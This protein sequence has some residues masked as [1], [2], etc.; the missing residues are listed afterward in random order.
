M[1]KMYKALLAS[2]IV[3]I[4]SFN[5]SAQQYWSGNNDS[6]V[7]ITTD[8]GV[9]RVAYPKVFRL[10]NLN[11]D[12]LRQELFSIVDRSVKRSTIITLPNADGGLEQ[13]EVWEAS[14][15]DPALQAR[16]PLIRAYSGR[17][18]TDRYSTS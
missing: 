5:A 3:S 13:F 4:I 15:F 12:P 10:F 6:R 7:S 9:A 16:Y 1:R 8:K 11:I 2:I 14:N 17:G 18:I